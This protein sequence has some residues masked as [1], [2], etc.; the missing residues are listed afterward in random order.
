MTATILNKN[1]TYNSGGAGSNGNSVTEKN[2]QL[3]S[4]DLDAGNGS[5][6]QTKSHY[7]QMLPYILCLISFASVLSI[8]CFYMDTTGKFKLPNFLEQLLP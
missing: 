2:H 3:P 6:S 1:S 8:L 7:R 5:C 4:A